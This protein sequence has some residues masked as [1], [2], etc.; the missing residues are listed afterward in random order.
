MAFKCYSLN[1]DN[2]EKK[3]CD[4]SVFFFKF[5]FLIFKCLFLREG[6]QGRERD[7]E[8]GKARAGKEWQRERETQNPKQA[9]GPG[10]SAQ[11][12]TQGSNS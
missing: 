3:V 10:L 8:G 7:R 4:E 9:P 5:L 11:S 1:L 12:L 2:L 6:G